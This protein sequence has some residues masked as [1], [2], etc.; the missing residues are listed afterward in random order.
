MSSLS[1]VRSGPQLPLALDRELATTQSGNS[2][3]KLPPC[4]GKQGGIWMEFSLRDLSNQHIT[5]LLEV[6]STLPPVASAFDFY[7]GWNLAV[8]LLR[9]FHILHARVNSSLILN[10]LVYPL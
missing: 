10:L 9:P 7:R 4:F 5:F 3:E 1:P 2:G 6:E 8:Q